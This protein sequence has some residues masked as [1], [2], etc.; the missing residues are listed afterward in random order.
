MRSGRPK[1][2]DRL[3]GTRGRASAEGQVG[4]ESAVWEMPD[5]QERGSGTDLTVSR[6]GLVDLETDGMI[7]MFVVSSLVATISTRLACC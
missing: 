1:R 3:K 6:V 7:L 5:L 2:E 4:D